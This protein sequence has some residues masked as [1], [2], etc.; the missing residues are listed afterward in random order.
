M[1]Y[2]LAGVRV[3]DLTRLL[4]GGLCTLLL[5]DL[6][7]DLVKVEDPHGGDYSRAMPPLIPATGP[8][9]VGAGYAALKRG[10]RSL[11]LDLKQPGDRARFLALAERADVVV[12]GFRPG[13]MERLGV[14]ADTLRERNPRL[15]YCALT[16]YGQSGPLANTVGHDINYIGTVGLLD[17]NG[18]HAGP[19]V[20]PGAQLADLSGALVAALGIL[21]ALVRRATTGAGG[22]V[23]TSMAEA[24]F[25]L[26]SLPWAEWAATGQAAGRGSHILNGGWACYN[27]YTAADGWHLALGCLEAKFWAAF[28]ALVER[29][30]WVAQQFDP[31]A[32]AELRAAV[33]A[34]FASRP[35]AAWLALADGRDIPLTLVNA[36]GDVSAEPQLVARQMF[37]RVAD[38]LVARTPV[39]LDDLPPAA[40][41]PPPG[42]GTTT[43]DEILHGWQS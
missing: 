15:I 32:Q 30:A 2:P 36:L 1:S 13:V 24:A 23:D 4:P 41:A 20:V 14:G 38:H 12:E 10:K 26:L 25:A 16:G 29:P 7:A 43:V 31:A 3:L 21:A 27:V 22:V 42:Y 35:A 33:A 28:C 11:V 17:L 40:V 6:G 19:P 5:A 8:G 39:R 37:L 34:L 18:P 9:E